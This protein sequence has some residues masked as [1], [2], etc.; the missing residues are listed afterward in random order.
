[1][2]AKL[3]AKAKRK[4]GS[5]AELPVSRQKQGAPSTDGGRKLRSVP[6][7]GERKFESAY[8]YFSADGREFVITRPDTP[9]PWVNIISNG[10]YGVIESQTGSGF[11]WRYNSNLSRVTRWEQDLIRDEWGKY[12]YVRDRESGEYW[13]GTWK[14]CCNK[15]DFYEVRHGQG[16]SVLTA[17]F[18]SIKTKKTVFVD[19]KNPAEIWKIVL[20]N[21]SNRPRKLSLFPY[22][23]WCLGNAADT[24]REFQKTF[25]ETEYIKEANMLWGL[26]RAALVPGFISTGLT[27]NPLRG[28]LACPNI[29]PKSYDGDKETFFG[30]YNDIRH[31]QSVAD[32]MLKNNVGRWGDSI[33][34]L[35][36][37]VD[38]KPGEKKTVIFVIGSTVEKSEAKKIV[39]QYAT[40][41]AVEA[42]LKEVRALWDRFVTA[43]SI[44][45]PDPALNFMTN[46]WLKYQ[47]I[48]ARLWARSAYFQQ[49]GAFGF[50]DQLQ[51][52]QIFLSLK[53]EL[54]KKQI[55]LH[56]ENQF[57]DGT[58][59]HWWHPGTR[60]G[61]ITG[62]SDDLLWLPYMLGFYI[63]ET[64]D[65]QIL[66]TEINFLPD[67]N[68]KVEKGTL[69]KH[70][71]RA[72]EKVI[73]RHSPRGLPLIGEC[74]WNDGLSHVGV[75]WKGESIWLGQFLY[76]I[77]TKFAPLMEE[78]G[79]KE[80]AKKYRK[81][82]AS[83]K[84]AIDEHAWDG[85]WYIGATRD[86]GLP[87]GSH[88]CEEGKIFLNTQTWA[89]INSTAGPERAKQCMASA[90]KIL[91][92]E[93][94]PLL[95]T[96]GYSKT[97]AHIGYITR[98][99]PSI[100]E[101]GGVY[102][103]A[104]TWA[105]IAECLMGKGDK[106]FETYK[107][108][109]PPYRGLDPDLYFGEP[110]VTP[111][112]IDGPDSPTF[113]RGGWTWYTGSAAWMYRVGLDWICGIHA[114]RKG[115][116]IDPVIPKD[117][118]GFKARRLFR[119]ASYEIEV[120][121]PSG[122][123]RGVKEIRVDGKTVKDGLIPPYADGKTHKVLVTMG[124]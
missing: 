113:G 70:C 115:L 87:L 69:Y 29:T 60:S 1:M 94:G 18:Q 49:S 10:D 27:E 68:G 86:D 43:S 73:S 21:E 81:H 66:D 16:Y 102:T 65:T 58:V 98:Y 110:Y 7:P 12:L 31:P 23:E 4:T 5:K 39:K 100:R 112:N 105:V 107:R 114:E 82:A 36:V 11:S 45:T 59:Y 13:S 64:D 14:P 91:F 119:G 25:I 20:Q 61:S 38:L 40:E 120:K 67:K 33:A 95:L 85:E 52:S 48:S 30:R 111:G 79:D 122:I 15:L 26:K 9:R 47:A 93:Y 3:E 89:I 42:G 28:F 124:K 24:H 78:R 37:D 92:R 2:P 19:V 75:H 96:P 76:G 90:E 46:I 123:N 51:D 53:P 118:P 54:A 35:H 41:A 84:D 62:S 121:N 44:E 108:M 80:R 104:A 106:A 83:V 6:H 50:R 56:A 63:D 34:A 17:S 77:L 101:N 32:G 57:P 97:D 8:G 71:I 88:T 103:H 74:D 22:F 116:R 99:A 109:A 72:M 55:L 117:W